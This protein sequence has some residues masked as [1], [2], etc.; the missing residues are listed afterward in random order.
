M[1]RS[2]LLKKYFG[3]Y[4][5]L[6]V[7]NI[8]WSIFLD[9]NAHHYCL[10]SSFIGNYFYHNYFQNFEYSIL[11]FVTLLSLNL[12]L[13]DYFIIKDLRVSVMFCKLIIFTK[14]IGRIGML[15]WIIVP[16]WL[17]PFLFFASVYTPWFIKNNHSSSLKN[18]C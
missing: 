11:L 1:L 16:E 8:F 18:G 17:L 5:F 9:G 10:I 15:D 3:K 7:R 2:T 6:I 13:L 4:A 14:L 12:Q